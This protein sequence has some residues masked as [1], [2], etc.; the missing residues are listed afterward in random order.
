M[1]YIIVTNNKNKEN[2][3]YFQA[4]F[5]TWEQIPAEKSGNRH[6]LNLKKKLLQVS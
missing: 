5:S 1:S 2:Y 6:F 3:S 4:T